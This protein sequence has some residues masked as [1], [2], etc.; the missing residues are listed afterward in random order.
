[1]DF[2]L[3]IG[4]VHPY[5]GP[6]LVMQVAACTRYRAECAAQ[7]VVDLLAAAVL[8]GSCLGEIAYHVIDV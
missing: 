3:S 4:Q 6:S 1:M 2:P 5:F 7:G 8:M